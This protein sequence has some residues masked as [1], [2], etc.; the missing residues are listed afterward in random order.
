[1]GQKT[2]PFSSGNVNSSVMWESSV[3]ITRHG[4]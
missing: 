3:R 1:M 4:D 2:A